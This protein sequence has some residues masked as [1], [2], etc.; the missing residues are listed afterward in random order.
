M[1]VVLVLAALL[2]QVT[3]SSPLPS[4]QR[5][6]SSKM[7]MT[8]LTFSDALRR[9]IA[10]AP[11]DFVSD[12]GAKGVSPSGLTGYYL[13]FHID[14]LAHC[15]VVPLPL[16]VAC[17]AYRGTDGAKARAAFESQTAQLQAFAGPNAHL[18]KEAHTASGYPMVS[19]RPGGDVEVSV[20][21]GYLQNQYL[22]ALYVTHKLSR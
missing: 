8:T 1:P 18:H 7:P 14:G 16:F 21:M 6:A 20:E 15:A 10:D 3:S 9:L 5:T 4:P 2:A 11:T 13:N 22:V 19:Y 17:V 12:R